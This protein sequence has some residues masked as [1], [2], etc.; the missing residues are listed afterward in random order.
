MLVFEEKDKIESFY[1]VTCVTYCFTCVLLELLFSLGCYRIYVDRADFD[2]VYMYF[3]QLILISQEFIQQS[4]SALKQVHIFRDDTTHSEICTWYFI[5]VI[6]TYI[7]YYKSKTFN[8]KILIMVSSEQIIPL[9][10]KTTLQQVAINLLTLDHS[11]NLEIN[12][13][14]KK[15][16][17]LWLWMKIWKK[18]SNSINNE[19][20]TKLKV[21]IN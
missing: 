14:F 13:S 11:T 15:I 3:F 12:I 17:A 2:S 21:S 20:K 10:Q 19:L 8:L 1:S 6:Q 16:E 9:K 18:W 5:Y 4:L 7:T